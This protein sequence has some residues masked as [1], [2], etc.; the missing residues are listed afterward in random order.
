MLILGISGS[1][2]HAATEFCVQYALEWLQAHA[3]QRPVETHYFSVAGKDVR[4]CTHCDFCLR[5]KRGCTFHDDV[6]A[7]YPLMERADAWVVGTPVYQSNY[8]AQLKAVLDRCRALVAR[9]PRIFEG[10]V[11]AAIAVGG[12]RNGGQELAIQALHAFFVSNFFTVVGG[13]AFGANLGASVWARDEGAAGAEADAE[14]LRAIRKVARHVLQ[15]LEARDARGIKTARD[16][17]DAHDAMDARE[18]HDPP[19]TT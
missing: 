2:R 19:E 5:E 12:D 1:P 13:G 15:V 8:S 18:T 7:L 11:G 17:K 9:A 4:F 16:A 3:G 10:K 6:A 14:G